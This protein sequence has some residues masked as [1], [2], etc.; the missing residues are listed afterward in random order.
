MFRNRHNRLFERFRDHADGEALGL[1]FDKTAPRLFKL[2]CHLVREPAVAEDLVQSTFLVAVAH[3]EKFDGS[4]P[5]EGWLY[6]ILWRE[7]ARSRRQAARRPESLET[8]PGVE[9]EPLAA[10]LSAETRAAVEEVIARLPARHR[11][12][13]EPFLCGE[14][15]PEE[16][17]VTLG[18]AP[19]TVR[20]QIHRAMER[21]RRALPRGLEAMPVLVGGSLRGLGPVRAQVLLRAGAASRVGL[22]APATLTGLSLG[23]ILVTKQAMALLGVAVLLAGWMLWNP[24]PE[25][26]PRTQ[27]ASQDG[28]STVEIVPTPALPLGSKGGDSRSPVA[29]DPVQDLPNPAPQLETGADVLRQAKACMRPDLTDPTT[30]GGGPDAAAIWQCLQSFDWMRVTP[31]ELGEWLCAEK[32]PLQQACR[33]IGSALHARAPKEALAYLGAYNPPC[34]EVRETGLQIMAVEA[35]GLLDPKWVAELERSMTSDTL[36]TGDSSTQGILLAEL[37]IRD[38]NVALALILEK[39]GRG[40]YGGSKGEIERAAAASLF[41]ASSGQ[42]DANRAGNAWVYAESLVRSPT[43]PP[44]VGSVLGGALASKG[45]WPGGDSTVAMSTLSQAMDDPRFTE[46]IAATLFFMQKPAG[47]DGCNKVLWDEVYAK[48]LAVAAKK[49]WEPLGK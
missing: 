10:L 22:P 34:P 48:V 42:W 3:P 38:G 4:G 26:D 27:V 23:A 24:K 32:L 19:S 2:A 18:R 41:L 9:S 25:Q 5:V 37:F 7:A 44:S 46:S 21:L 14:Q 43:T 6:G 39:G 45:T 47:P 29:A 13:L 31:A 17:A 40:E 33:V 20:T 11:E 16:I 35:I 15:R 1:L 28:P 36:F 30:P 8:E 12:V 49:G